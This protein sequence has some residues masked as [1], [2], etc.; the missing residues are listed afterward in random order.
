MDY[1]FPVFFVLLWSLIFAFIEVL[2][3]KFLGKAIDAQA[4]YS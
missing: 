3:G 1:I 2:L 4:R